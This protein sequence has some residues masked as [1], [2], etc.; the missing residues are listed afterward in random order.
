MFVMQ[1]IKKHDPRHGPHYA[2]KTSDEPSSSHVYPSAGE[3]ASITTRLSGN[4][5][6]ETESTLQRAALA[7]CLSWVIS[8]HRRRISECPLYPESGPRRSRAC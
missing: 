2:A 1:P 4:W 8:G 7:W 3:I 6:G 5:N